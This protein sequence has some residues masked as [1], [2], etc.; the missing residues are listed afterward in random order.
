VEWILSIAIGVL[1]FF[2]IRSFVF[3]L[4]HVDGSSMEPTLFHGD[5]IILN[6]FT[7]LFS[8]PQVGDIVA[9][10]YPQNPSEY[11]IKRIIAVPGDVVDLRDSGF[12]I[13]GV[14]LSDEFADYP[15]IARGDVVFPVTVAEGHYFML[16]DNRN[17]SVDSRFRSVGTIAAR[18]MVGKVALRIWPLE[19][20]G[21][22][23]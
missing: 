21:T 18:N 13:N 5:M 4:A 23:D 12:Y 22:V 19:R 9:F 15:I 8:D 17:G 7:Y 10:P 14:A 3:R 6:R 2:V 1:I 20:L 16:G 11:Y